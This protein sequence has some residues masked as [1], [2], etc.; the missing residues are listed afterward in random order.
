MS[1][2]LIFE[3]GIVAARFRHFKLTESRWGGIGR[4]WKR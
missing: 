4:R 3:F 1:A 2:H